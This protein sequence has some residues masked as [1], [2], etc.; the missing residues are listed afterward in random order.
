[1]A[2]A[3]K[4]NVHGPASYFQNTGF[5]L[6]GYPCMGAW[7]SYALGSIVDN[8]PTFVVLP[9]ARG[10]PY[11]NTGNFSSAFLPASHTGTVIKPSAPQP[12][13]FL[14]APAAAKQI[15]PA[16]ETASLALIDKLNREHLV[17]RQGDTR[18]SAR[19]DSLE[20]AA[21][22]QLSAPEAIDLAREAPATHK[23][24]GL[25]RPETEGMARNCLLARRLLERGVRFVQVWSGMGGPSRNWDNHTDIPKELPFIAGSADQPMAALILDLKQRGMLDDTLVIGTT[26]FGRMP[27]TQSNVG[28]DHNQGTFVTWLA[29]GGIKAGATFGKS[30]DF[31]FATAEGKTYVYDLH[32]T[33]LHLLGIDHTRLTFRHDGI[34]RR[35]TDVHGRVIR[36][37]LDS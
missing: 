33:I 20:L 21:K 18:L 12:I 7:I 9:D 31:A 22:M 10:L 32:A 19:I 27:C 2:C 28:R 14:R 29:G 36:E 34:D 13:A 3:S 35:L 15:T 16:S 8:L 17:E 6:P 1:M 4:S 37:V 26:E 24:Y 11:N 5:V 25:D 30:D 23:L